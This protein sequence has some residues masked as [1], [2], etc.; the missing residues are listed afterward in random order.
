MRYRKDGSETGDI[1]SG[2]E[3]PENLIDKLSVVMD[4]K[5]SRKYL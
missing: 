5:Q 3:A 2:L 1:T 4:W